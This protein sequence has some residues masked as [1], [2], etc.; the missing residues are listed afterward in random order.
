M[1]A[2]SIVEPEKQEARAEVVAEHESEVFDGVG[3]I[4]PVAALT[5]VSDDLMHAVAEALRCLLSDSDF[6]GALQQAMHM[7]SEAADVHRFKV[8]LSRQSERPENAYHELAHEWFAPFLDSQASHGLTRFPDALIGPYLEP[9]RKGQSQWQLI[10]DVQGPLRAPFE[11]VGMQSMGVVPIFAGSNYA[12]VVAFDDCRR[13]REWTVREIDA[14]TI[15]AQGVGAAIYH[16]ELAF[17]EAA[18]ATERDRIGRFL[19]KTLGAASIGREP[20]LSIEAIVEGLAQELGAVHVFLFRHDP[21]TDL[22]RLT[23]SWIDGHIRRGMSGAEL[24]LFEAPFRSDITPAWAIMTQS[25]KLFTPALIPIT[26][27]EFGW[28]GA[29]EYAQRVGLS[30]MGHIVL[31]AENQP[32]GS[33]GFS[34]NDGRRLT[35]Q[36]G[37]FVEGLASHVARVI[38]IIDLGEESKRAALLME[39]KELNEQKA[40]EA[41]R[42][43]SALQATVD[44]LQD[45]ENVEEIVP[46]LL[47]IVARTFG[48]E[49][50]AAFDNQRDGSVRLLYWHVGARTMSPS[51]LHASGLLNPET[52]AVLLT[53]AEGFSVPDS[54]LGISA[55]EAVGPFILDHRRGTTVPE[56]DDFAVS[57]GWDLELNVGVG[58][59]GIRRSTLCIYRPSCQP[60]SAA[61]QSLAESLA[62][63]MALAI[64]L[65]QLAAEARQVALAVERAHA[66]EQRTADAARANDILKRANDRLAAEPELN[67]FIGHILEELCALLDSPST[68]VIFEH[69]PDDNTLKLVASY[70]EGQVSRQLPNFPWLAEGGRVGTDDD[71]WRALY[72]T[73]SPVTF[74]PFGRGPQ[75]RPEVMDWMRLHG[76]IEVLNYPLTVGDKVAGFIGLGFTRPV[77]LDPVKQEL[78]NFLVQQTSIAF[79][80]ARLSESANSA[81]LLEERNRIARD[82][83][84]TMAQSFTGIYMQL[85][86]ANRYTESNPLLAR[87]CID[88]AQVLAREG[89]VS[90]THLTLPT[91]REV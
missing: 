91:N 31:F 90:Y 42:A 7:V 87:A 25:P 69:E 89:P 67:S 51:E 83:H 12:G 73:K 64:G 57:N 66:A 30:D 61:E 5:G 26:P 10:D 45:I 78:V 19:E 28:P 80:A 46:R 9:A 82:L 36:D 47:G 55:I 49:A 1:S 76:I 43:S 59:Q 32:I 84:D 8:I 75:C 22:I 23:V 29:L 86:A 39:R 68:A 41:Q 60:F 56:F 63:Q 20:Y 17:K 33:I 77:N 40:L 54:Y 53:L 58:A 18:A 16:R 21:M 2:I 37:R 72:S 48:A 88:R 15:A 62:K 65:A 81:S 50:C 70:V 35:S 71:F 52:V 34:L 13:R 27:Q 6:D 74:E 79:R 24:A 11:Q 85:Q 38:R 4:R 14:L 44:A 3:R